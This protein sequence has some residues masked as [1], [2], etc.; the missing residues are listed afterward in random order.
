MTAECKIAKQTGQH[1]T[2]ILVPNRTKGQGPEPRQEFFSIKSDQKRN[3]C[4]IML[5][6]PAYNDAKF[7]YRG[8][9]FFWNLLIL[10]HSPIK[11]NKTTFWLAF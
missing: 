6:L 1:A 7:S 11:C 10:S 5:S 2:H 4:C 9:D 3:I 8:N